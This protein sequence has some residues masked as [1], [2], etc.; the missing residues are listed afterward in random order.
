MKLPKGNSFCRLQG[1]FEK[2]C[3]GMNATINEKLTKKFPFMPTKLS[4]HKD[5]THPIDVYNF[6]QYHIIF[7]SFLWLTIND[8]QLRH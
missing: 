7:K 5:T 8:R 6:S 3:F 1:K 4:I 2:I